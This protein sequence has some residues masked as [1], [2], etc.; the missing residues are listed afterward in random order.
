[1]YLSLSQIFSHHFFLSFLRWGETESTW[2]VGHHFA[3]SRTMDD[4]ECGAVGCMIDRGNRNTRRK[5]A[6]VPRFPPQIPHDVTR[7]RTRA[8][9][10]GSL[11][12]TA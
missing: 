9:A 12:L 2:Y 5:T 11:G 10:V 8:A 4:D 3:R 7:V 1:M 6:S